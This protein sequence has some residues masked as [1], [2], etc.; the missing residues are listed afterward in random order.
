MV[1]KSRNY[2]CV[3]GYNLEI[4]MSTADLSTYV[5]RYY[6]NSVRCQNS[7]K[8]R[9]RIGQTEENTAEG[10]GYVDVINHTTGVLETAKPHGDGKD[11]HG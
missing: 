4:S 8:R 3:H 11:T 5:A 2:L 10:R 6:S 1:V 9:E 7:G